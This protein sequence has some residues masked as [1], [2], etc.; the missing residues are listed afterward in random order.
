MAH[1]GSVLDTITDRCEQSSSMAWNDPYL[2]IV[3][4]DHICIID[5]TDPS[6]LVSRDWEER[7]IVLSSDLIADYRNSTLFY[8]CQSSTRG[9]Y[10]WDMTDPDAIVTRDAITS[11]GEVGSNMLKMVQYGNYVYITG[12][13]ED[14]DSN[15]V[16]TII[17]VT[18]PDALVEETYFRDDTNLPSPTVAI[19]RYSH[20]LIVAGT[21]KLAIFD[22]STP[23]EPSYLGSV[24]IT[25]EITALNKLVI[26]AEGQYAYLTRYTTSKI[27][28]IDISDK[29][30]PT[31]ADTFTDATYSN[32]CRHIQIVGS[33]L[34]MYNIGGATHYISA[35]N[36][37]DRETPVFVEH[38]DVTD[39][40]GWTLEPF[41]VDP[42]QNLYYPRSDAAAQYGFQSVSIDQKDDGVYVELAG[43]EVQSQAYGIRI[44]RGRE[45]E[46][47][48]APAGVAELTMDNS[49][50]DFSPE[51][52]GGAYYG[53]L[54][55]GNSIYIYEVYGGVT[56]DLF[57]GQ[58][59]KI[60]P[61]DVAGDGGA[62]AFILCTDGMDDLNATPV[63]TVL[64]TS[65]KAGQLIEDILDDAVAFVSSRDIDTGITTFDVA[66]FSGKNA[67]PQ[68]RS[69]ED[70]ERGRFY[71]DVDGDA[72][73]ED[74][75]HRILNH[76]TSEYDFGTK[77][78]A[79]SYEWSKRDLANFVKIVGTKYTED[80]T[81]EY[82]WGTEAGVAATAVIVPANGSVTIWA[83][84]SQ[85][86]SSFTALGAGGTYWN[87]NTEVDKSGTDTT[88]SVSVAATQY[89][90]AIKMVFTS[91]FNADSYLVVPDSPPAA[92]DANRTAIVM[93]KFYQEDVIQHIEE[94]STSQT[95]YGK[96]GLPITAPFMSDPDELLTLA[97]FLIARHKN[98]QPMAIRVTIHAR[99]D[100]PTDDILKQALARK[101]SDR[102]TLASTLLGFDQDF[103]IEKVIHDYKQFEGKFNLDVTWVCSRASEQDSLTW[104]LEIAGFGELE[105]TTYLSY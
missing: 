97:V 8:I 56:Y 77:L 105:E 3:E 43:T 9:F 25:T 13:K 2:I 50:G 87:T 37:S 22:I 99:T 79:I 101:I 61:Q 85:V 57:T 4:R 31:L 44:E 42:F 67:L 33:F 76:R 40:T 75:H 58:I 84:F 63:E 68:I 91:T 93:G 14:G 45:T 74:R 92:A 36:V 5:A 30:S 29:T 52:S 54:D 11:L 15:G 17:N 34:Y 35:W 28:I 55:L 83:I 90:K 98:P 82:L 100:W 41:Y 21:T 27:D 26:D 65:V 6:A 24:T 20:Y 39:A 86:L 66:F 80:A 104:L 73:F 78:R 64:R 53:T 71:I 10:C 70:Q 88:A 49:E 60:V 59:E 102:V 62:Q 69:V 38:F 81:T 7:A 32:L 72:Q 1:F 19:A 51:N 103:Y 89:G 18:D 47:G 12:N 96:K 94:D 16:I 46:L 95:A 48:Y 23:T